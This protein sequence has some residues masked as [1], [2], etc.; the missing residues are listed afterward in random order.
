MFIFGPATFTGIFVPQEGQAGCAIYTTWGYH[1]LIH[2]GTSI[3]KQ[4]IINGN[5]KKYWLIRKGTPNDGT[6]DKPE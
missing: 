1:V 5:I 3:V 6:Q 4:C 2:I